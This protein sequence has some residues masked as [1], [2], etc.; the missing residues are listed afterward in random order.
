M[1]NI[2]EWAFYDCTSLSSVS[3]PVATTIGNRAFNNCTSLSSVDFGDTPRSSVPTLGNSAFAGV[4]TTCKIIVPDAQYDEWIASPNWSTLYA[5]GY[6][7]LRHSEWEYARKYEIA[8]KVDSMENVS[9][10]DLKLKRDNGELVPGSEYRI[11]NY[12]ATSNGDMSSRA[13]TN[14]FDIIVVADAT[15]VLNETARAI[16]HDG[17]TYFPAETKFEA[18]RLQYCI[19]NDT[20]RFAWAVA[21]ADGGRGVIY[22][23]VDEFEND[24]PYDFKGL[25]FRRWAITNVTSTKLTPEAVA[26]Y[27]TS[28]VYASNGGKCFAYKNSNIYVNGTV[29][30]VDS[31]TSA[32][33]YTFDSGNGTDYSLS[34]GGQRV[35]G[36]KMREYLV[37]G[38]AKL[39][40]SV[41]LGNDCYYNT[42]GNDCYSNT[43][44]AYC[45][46]NTFGDDCYSSTF[47]DRCYSNT[48][49]D[50]CYSSTFGNYY[51]SSTFGNDCSHN[52]FGD[53]CS[54][55]T[56]GND[57]SYN[58][59][60]DYCFYNTFGNDCYFITFGTSSAPKSY[61]RY[62]TVESGNQYIY[63]NPTGTTSYSA[64]YQN[65]TIKS[66]VNNTTT[67]KTI[68][69]PNVNQDFNTT[70]QPKNSQVI[71][72]E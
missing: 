61:C 19:N 67:Y 3:L 24:V 57:C 20:N 58:T 44:G 12:W 8:G 42:F 54:Y 15:N 27:I 9:W 62:I 32:Y 37:S 52:T 45:Y 22:R 48:F 13:V 60:G 64:C 26:N 30:T 66:G 25:Q 34:G 65:V 29:M 55:N 47:G 71:E 1:T 14:Q 36:N 11:T 7:F 28:F 17:D 21:D 50:D 59:F 41:F 43:F 16:R 2:W 46:S 51:Y 49:G 35:Y 5:N 68:T 23:M 69:D 39:H 33:Y 6:Q 53:Y 4:P 31:S 70:Y 63:L 40:S 10:E 72:V 18:W 38:K 56:F